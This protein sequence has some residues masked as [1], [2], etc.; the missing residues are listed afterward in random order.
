[1][2]WGTAY[3]QECMATGNEH[4]ND[5]SHVHFAA[6]M[7][8]ACL[9]YTKLQFHGDKLETGYTPDRF[10]GG[11]LEEITALIRAGTETRREGG[12]GEREGG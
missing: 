3:V 11:T 4:I 12:E 6:I 5:C 2:V 8:F 10:H 9:H 1:M 7:Q